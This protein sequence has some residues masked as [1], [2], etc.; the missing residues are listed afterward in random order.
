MST[1]WPTGSR[2]RIGVKAQLAQ[3]RKD[4][5]RLEQLLLLLNW[6]LQA[7]QG[8]RLPKNRWLPVV[9]PNL[10]TPFL[11]RTGPHGA[12]QTSIMLGTVEATEVRDQLR[13]WAKCVGYTTH[14][15]RTFD[16]FE[17]AAVVAMRGMDAQLDPAQSLRTAF[18]EINEEAKGEK[19]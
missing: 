7:N 16:N 3:L 12:P 6:W 10:G 19:E 13:Y 1:T 2:K 4:H 9:S 15:R 11:L 18:P 17:Q 8:K 5:E 14:A